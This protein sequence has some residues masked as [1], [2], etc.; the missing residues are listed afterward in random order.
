MTWHRAEFFSCD[1]RIK[2]SSFF[3][4]TFEIYFRKFLI[5]Q[6]N[7]AVATLLNW[8]IVLFHKWV[9]II[10]LSHR[11]AVRDNIFP[12]LVCITIKDIYHFF[13][14]MMENVYPSILARM[15]RSDPR[16][17]IGKVG[18]TYRRFTLETW[19]YHTF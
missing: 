1:R 13:F 18:V 6:K 4:Y 7:I 2:I 14:C 10:R 19:I 11:F 12:L 5:E 15:S 3:C 17:F 9:R 16:F 8:I